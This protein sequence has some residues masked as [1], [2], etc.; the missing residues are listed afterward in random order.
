MH[1]PR[2]SFACV[3]LLLLVSTG[4][5]HYEYDLVE[6]ADVAQ[7]VGTKQSVVIPMEPL[8][9]EA[10]SASD[11]LVLFVFNESGEPVKL[12]GDDSFAV[13]PRGESHPLPTR[14]VAAGSS[15][16]LIF[17]PVRPTFRQSGPTIGV[18]VGVGVAHS[19]GRR[20]YYRGGGVAGDPCYSDEPR[21]Y[22]LEDDGT[23]YWDWTGDGTAV[24]LRLVY[25]Q[26][27]K[28]FHHD[29]TFKR[30]KM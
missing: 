21:Y 26:G 8:R 1:L 24:K 30:V 2:H 29:F 9:Y 7:H 10:R 14:T 25:Q 23:V 20:G 4:C 28:Q 3:L 17:P 22:R 15:T 12:L 16:K 11:R 6:P 18:G 13:D 27:D 5:A 19:Y